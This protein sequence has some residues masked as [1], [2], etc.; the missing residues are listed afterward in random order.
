MKDREAWYAELWG[1][2]ESGMTQQLNN[3]NNNDMIHLYRASTFSL[4]LN[5]TTLV[6]SRKK[7]SLVKDHRANGSELGQEFIFSSMFN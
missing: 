4:T 1:C 3:S 7:V 6:S 2:K 5:T